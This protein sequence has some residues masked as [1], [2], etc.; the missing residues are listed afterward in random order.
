[1]SNFMKFQE[2]VYNA[3]NG[4][5]Q[6]L[7]RA[8]FWYDDENYLIKNGQIKLWSEFKVKMLDEDP[9]Y[10]NFNVGCFVSLRWDQIERYTKFKE[11]DY[12]G[13]VTYLDTPGPDFSFFKVWAH[14][15]YCNSELFDF[16]QWKIWHFVVL[17]PLLH[18]DEKDDDPD[19]D[20]DEDWWKKKWLN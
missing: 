11:Y 12:E 5:T 1:M 17:R 7:E 9:L 2:G 19:R 13:C 20:F 8:Y 6:V 15:G 10:F 16:W 18:E 3:F 14:V 4:P